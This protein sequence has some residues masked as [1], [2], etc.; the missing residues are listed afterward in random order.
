MPVN[1]QMP[2]IPN[3]TLGSVVWPSVSYSV[4]PLPVFNYPG[5]GDVDT[6]TPPEFTELTLPPPEYTYPTATPPDKAV[7]HIPTPPSI[8]FSQF[9][10]TVPEMSVVIPDASVNWAYTAYLNLILD[11]IALQV[12]TLDN[13]TDS[14]WANFERINNA[15]WDGTYNAIEVFGYTDVLSSYRNKELAYNKSLYAGARDSLKEAIRVRNLETYLSIVLEIEK[16]KRTQYSMQK[17]LELVFAKDAIKKS[18]EHYNLLLKQYEAYINAYRVMSDLY[19]AEVDLAGKRIQMIE[20]LIAAEKVKAKLARSILAR[21]MAEVKANEDLISLYNAQMQLAKKEAEAIALNIDTFRVSVEAF[22]LGVK[23]IVELAHQQ[24]LSAQTATIMAKTEEAQLYAA[25]VRI[26]AASLQVELD[27]LKNKYSTELKIV[28]SHNT[29]MQSYP[30]ALEMQA[31]SQGALIDA[32]VTNIE[33][34]ERARLA[35]VQ[36]ELAI[37]NAKPAQAVADYIAAILAGEYRDIEQSRRVLHGI[38][39]EQIRYQEMERT[40]DQARVDMADELKNAKLTN[41]F[42]EYNS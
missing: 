6:G 9:T 20:A 3:V 39:M 22:I 15:T 26:K 17:D 5:L 14:V 7:I 25:D 4:P 36:A 42:T 30:P 23:N 32:Q 21:Y 24:V 35:E 38:V 13:A 41:V 2:T 16:Q 19:V 29:M 31:E 10:M 18:I 12:A 33:E 1:F 37:S 34:R 11:T 28:A 40:L 27:A 8:T